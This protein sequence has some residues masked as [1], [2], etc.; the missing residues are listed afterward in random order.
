MQETGIVIDLKNEYAIVKMMRTEACDKCRACTVG[1][2]GKEMIIE[3]E[4][5]CGAK[6]GDKVAIYL[7]QENFIKAVLIMYTI[8]LIALLVGLAVGYYI[9]YL[10]DFDLAEYLSILTGFVFLG[11]SYYFIRKNESKFKQKKFRPQIQQIIK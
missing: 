10:I 2:E 5:K 8:P 6:L 3:A 1:I 4:N 9:G 11:F 7:E